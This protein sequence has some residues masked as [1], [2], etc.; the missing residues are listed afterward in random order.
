MDGGEFG[1][2]HLES[3][4]GGD[5]GIV[6]GGGSFRV[7]TCGGANCAFGAEELIFMK[8]KS[9]TLALE[10]AQGWGTRHPRLRRK[11]NRGSL[12]YG[13]DAPFAQDEKLI[14]GIYLRKYKR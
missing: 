4:D 6:G 7:T 14:E 11:S 9:P 5:S 1:A 8:A 13:R 12:G 2:A 3:G 10:N